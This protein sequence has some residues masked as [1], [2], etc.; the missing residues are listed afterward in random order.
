MLT[1]TADIMAR[2]EMTL[3]P[4]TDIYEGMAL[5]L[6]HRLT[7]VPVVDSSSTLRGM[8]TERDCLKV[9]VG[10]AM[11]GLPVAESMTI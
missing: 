2:S 3:S 4:D 7:G 9:V 5:L 10:A 6:K 8:L 11:D 1:C